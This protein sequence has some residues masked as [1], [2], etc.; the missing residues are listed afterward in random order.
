MF[1]DDYKYLVKKPA[2]CYNNLQWYIEQGKRNY[3]LRFLKTNFEDLTNFTKEKNFTK[4]HNNYEDTYKWYNTCNTNLKEYMNKLNVIRNELI[5]TR[6]DFCKMKK[7]TTISDKFRD[8]LSDGLREINRCI[9]EV[10]SIKKEIHSELREFNKT[11][12]DISVYLKD[13]NKFNTGL[14]N[15]EN[16]LVDEYTR[17]NLEKIKL[18]EKGITTK[19]VISYDL[20]QEEKMGLPSK[21]STHNKR[22]VKELELSSFESKTELPVSNDTT[23]RVYPYSEY[24]N[25]IPYDYHK[26]TKN[27][28]MYK[29]IVGIVELVPKEKQSSQLFEEQKNAFLRCKNEQERHTYIEK[30]VS[31]YSLDQMGV[32]LL[33]RKFY[34]NDHDKMFTHTPYSLYLSSSHE[35]ET[36]YSLLALA[37]NYKKYRNEVC[38]L[39]FSDKKRWLNTALSEKPHKREL[40]LEKKLENFELALKKCEWDHFDNL[41]RVCPDKVVILEKKLKNNITQLIK[42]YNLDLTQEIIHLPTAIIDGRLVARTVAE[43]EGALAYTKFYGHIKKE[44]I[45][46]MSVLKDVIN[47]GLRLVTN[48][49]CLELNKDIRL[50]TIFTPLL[51]NEYENLKKYKAN[52]GKEQKDLVEDLKL[53]GKV[54]SHKMD[55]LQDLQNL[56]TTCGQN[57][58]KENYDLCMDDIKNTKI[59]I[60]KLNSYIAKTEILQQNHLNLIE[61]NSGLIGVE[62]GDYWLNRQSSARKFLSQVIEKSNYDPKSNVIDTVIESKE[63]LLEVEKEIP[64]TERQPNAQSYIEPVNIIDELSSESDSIDS[65]STCQTNPMGLDHID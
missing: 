54:K 16:F 18:S 45:T 8:E 38:A 41:R 65:V 48:D 39:Y 37:S 3:E 13:A 50:N 22:F 42:K 53:L 60:Y 51:I 44:D 14:K 59:Y 2:E 9:K 32:Y 63:E 19:E 11:N 31:E 17:L 30:L 27:W 52:G 24:Y 29:P 25:S 26:T 58:S 6:S 61:S 35:F 43:Q 15:W 47:E 49:L 64:N 34:Y 21:V 28:E 57:M 1:C 7:E 62:F 5:S 56:I 23:V 36:P 46:N 20:P 12:S 10:T 40:F 33:N 4:N 55:Q